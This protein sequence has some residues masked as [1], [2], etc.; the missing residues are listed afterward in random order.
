M[1]KAGLIIIGI[2][3]L[4]GTFL[5]LQVAFTPNDISNIRLANSLCT[6]QV[7]AFG[8]NIPIGQVGQKMIGAEQDCQKAHYIVLFLDYGFIGYIV[9]GF[10][11]ILGLALGN[12]RKEYSHERT[13]NRHGVKFCADCGARLEGHEKHCSECGAKI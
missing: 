3:I 7:T 2:L 5:F 12:E 11:F 1:A 8:I 10:L 9:G 6:T 13:S 4:I